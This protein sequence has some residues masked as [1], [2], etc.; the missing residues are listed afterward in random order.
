MVK[1]HESDPA[2]EFDAL[3]L[4]RQAEIT[5]V[6]QVSP[7]HDGKLKWAGNEDVISKLGELLIDVGILKRSGSEKE[8]SESQ[9]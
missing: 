9:G 2:G 4:F 1:S 5:A 8:T 3:A 7:R 6:S